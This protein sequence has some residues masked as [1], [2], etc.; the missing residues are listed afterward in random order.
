MTGNIVEFK[1]ARSE[2]DDQFPAKMKP[3]LYSS[4]C[5]HESV[6]VSEQERVVTCAHPKCEAVL[7]PIA[8]IARWAKDWDTERWYLGRAREVDRRAHDWFRRGGKISVTPSGVTVQLAG[9]KW[10]TRVSGGVTEQLK[11]AL[12]RAEQDVG[13]FENPKR[14]DSAQLRTN[15]VPNP[16]QPA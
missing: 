11:S 3:R 12:Q 14:N 5:K 10:S 9:R 15:V 13:T 2:P 4:E 1:P 7:D 6:I 8:V 16:E